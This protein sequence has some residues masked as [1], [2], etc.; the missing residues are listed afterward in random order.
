MIDGEKTSYNKLAGKGVTDVEYT[1]NENAK[2][3]LDKYGYIIN[4]DEAVSTSSYVFI[5]NAAT[6]TTL[7]RG[8]LLYRRHL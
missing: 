4:V 8:R 2:V 6:S 5:R 1:I 7:E 3:V